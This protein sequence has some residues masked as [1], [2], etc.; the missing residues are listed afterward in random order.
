MFCLIADNINISLLYRPAARA[1]ARARPT[2]KNRDP[3]QGSQDFSC[4]LQLFANHKV[5]FLFNKFVKV[6][7]LVALPTF[8][9]HKNT[10][11]ALVY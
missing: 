6:R 4:E 9:Q 2:P 7:R 3:M 11:E 5:L 1:R 8:H 10:R